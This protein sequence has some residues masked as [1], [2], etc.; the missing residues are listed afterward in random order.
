MLNMDKKTEDRW[1]GVIAALST[2]D[3]EWLKE[4]IEKE[5]ERV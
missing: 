2:E 4:E 1:K 5:L 3:L